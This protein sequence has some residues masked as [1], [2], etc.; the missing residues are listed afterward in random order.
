MLCF[1]QQKTSLP[2]RQSQ[3]QIQPCMQRVQWVAPK[4]T[5]VKTRRKEVSHSKTEHR[6]NNKGGMQTSTNKGSQATRQ[7]NSDISK[8]AS[9]TPDKPG[10]HNKLGDMMPTPINP[11]KLDYCLRRI[12]Y[13]RLIHN[14]KWPYDDTSVNGRIREERK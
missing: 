4:N 9:K 8:P 14:L 6:T 13:D 5:P 12:G 1:Q 2:I 10:Q 11:D 7:T 3:M